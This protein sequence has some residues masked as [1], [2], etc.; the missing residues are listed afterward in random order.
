M[1]TQPMLPTSPSRNLLRFL[2][3]IDSPAR[4]LALDVGCGYGRNAVALAERG[5]RVICVDRDLT[6]LTT[7]QQTKILFDKINLAERII[8][9]CAELGPDSWPFR[10]DQFDMVICIHVVRQDLFSYF[11]SSLRP[12]GYFY[13]ETFGGQ[14]GNFEALP[15][16]GEVRQSLGGLDLH[17]YREKQV[18]PPDR[19]SVTVKAL[20]R[21]P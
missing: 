21:K 5:W 7:L 11:L 15:H 6:R 8:P 18:G 19:E 9:I 10:R 20:A 3:R 12:G 1:L 17:Y 4:E 2:D 13:F 14:R 16:I